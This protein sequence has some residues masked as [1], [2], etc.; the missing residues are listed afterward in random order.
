M[1]SLLLH[2]SVFLNFP[3]LNCCVTGCCHRDTSHHRRVTP[4]R[5]FPLD[6]LSEELVASPLPLA[7]PDKMEAPLSL[8]LLASKPFRFGHIHEACY[9]S[10]KGT[11]QS[12][13]FSGVSADEE[14]GHARGLLGDNFEGDFRVHMVW[15]ICVRGV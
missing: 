1:Q 13:D 6:W 14:H 2:T 11:G 7:F 15:L 5:Q 10:I 4:R 12:A 8:G 3:H 9:L